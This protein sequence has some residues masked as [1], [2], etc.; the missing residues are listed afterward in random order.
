[1]SHTISRRTFLKGSLATVLTA[2]LA[3]TGLIPYAAADTEDGSLPSWVHVEAIDEA[4][5]T[6]TIE[7]DVVII[8]C[9]PSGYYTAASCAEN[10]LD[11]AVVC[12]AGSFSAFGGTHFVFN[13]KYQK[14]IGH[15]IADV[16]SVVQDFLAMQGHKCNERIVWTYAKR[17]GEAMNWL[18][19]TL[20]PYGLYPTLCD[21]NDKPIY[22][23]MPG[24]HTFYGGPNT[25]VD[26]S[27]NDPYTGD[28]GLGY[29][30]QVD[31]ATAMM[32]VLAERKVDVHFN[33]TCVSLV[34][35]GEKVTGILVRDENGNLK[36]FVGRKGVVIASGS[37][38]SNEEMRNT[39]CPTLQAAN[40]GEVNM[41]DFGDGSMHQQA[42]AIGA[43][44]QRMPDY[45]AMIFCGDAHPVWEMCVNKEGK[46]YMTEGIGTSYTSCAT[47]MQN[48]CKAYSIWC[49][50]YADQIRPVKADIIG[51]ADITPE[52]IRNG[53]NKLVDVGIFAKS[54][55]LDDIAEALGLPA[56]TLKATV[57]EYNSFAEAGE[58][59]DFHKDPSDLFPIQGTYYGGALGLAC[60]AVCGGLHVNEKSEVLTAESTPVENLYAVGLAAGDFWANTYTTRFPG[61]SLGHCLTFAYLLG[62]QLAG[63]E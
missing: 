4:S 28:L 8:G 32:S 47:L 10:G 36:K 44:M 46:R 60:L 51:G 41:F 50:D 18:I 5:V 38:G 20:E 57:E 22:G 62:R 26:V 61:N 33:T 63:I 31:V 17:S 11:T 58:D 7:K 37:F 12:K 40:A 29:V 42:V 34:K 6:E 19:D 1:M 49:D 39:F 16:P 56:D 21:H 59:A 45:A 9:G 25:P 14:E 3:G 30:P 48:G 35:E 27:D 52:M 23:T 2:G 55:S 15:E 24:G 53:W 43:S 54:E 13:S